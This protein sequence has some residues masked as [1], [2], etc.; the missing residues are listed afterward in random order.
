M[1]IED[2]L[3]KNS[4]IFKKSGDNLVIRCLNPDHVDLH[5]S[6]YVSRISGTAFC[7]SCKHRLDIY[8]Y[9]GLTKNL[10]SEKILEVKNK[11]ENLRR[12]NSIRL[13]VGYNLLDVEYRGI[14]LDTLKH[15][16]AFTCNSSEFDGRIWFPIYTYD[17]KLLLFQ[18]RSI[19]SELPPKYV[20]YPRG[21]TPPL[22]PND[23]D[24]TKGELIVVE[25]IMDVLNLWDNGIKNVICTFGT[26]KSKFDNRFSTYKISGINTLIPLYDNDRAGRDA[27][28][29]FSKIYKKSF[30]IKNV[31]IPEGKDP[32]SLSKSEILNLKTQLKYDII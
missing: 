9:F 30:I 20:F 11:L 14:S 27:T 7:F 28:E 31:S 25:G 29:K 18:G 16:G 24:L 1:N 17:K 3:T 19:G 23:A 21:I 26:G 13:P 22:Y 5:P 8:T 15:F 6:M 32:G 4:I 10:V 12:V 2:I